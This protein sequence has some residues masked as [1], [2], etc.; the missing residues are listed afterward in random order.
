ML[1]SACIG[2]SS[3]AVNS[4]GTP[5]DAS[6]DGAAPTCVTAADCDDG[7]ACTTDVCN[8]ACAHAAIPSCTAPCDAAH[9]CVTGHCDPASFTCVACLVDASCPPGAACTAH[10]CVS[11]P[12]CATDLDCKAVD[13][14]CAL[15]AGVCVDCL[16]NA[17]CAAG[18]RCEERH[19]VAR[20]PCASSK[21]CAKV[22]NKTAAICVDCAADSDCGAGAF[23][24]ELQRCR[25]A[26]CLGGTCAQGAYFACKPGG[27]RYLAGTTCDDN[28]DCTK[29]AC[30][31]TNC[32]H[33]T[34]SG[35]CD[36]A[37]TCTIDDVCNP[38]GCDGGA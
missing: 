27:S 6:S 7:D 17:D 30:T 5:T 35:A 12:N 11:A 18:Q 25:D 13:G 37:N 31:A 38:A 8:G 22:Y 21:D 10:A 2:C 9:P 19:C 36:D 1:A 16:S 24:D 34:T 32:T 15:P 28:N 4:G 29:D 20:P 3:N 26:V 14:V 33:A 23:C